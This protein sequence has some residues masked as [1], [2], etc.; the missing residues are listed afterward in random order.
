MAGTADHEGLAPPG[1]HDLYAQG[2]F[3]LALDVEVAEGADV[4]DLDIHH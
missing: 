3:P 1:R 4:M 2:L